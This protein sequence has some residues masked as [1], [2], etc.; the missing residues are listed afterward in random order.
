MLTLILR[1]ALTPMLIL[2]LMLLLTLILVLMLMSILNLI[3]ILLLRKGQSFFAHVV[4][5]LTWLLKLEMPL[6]AAFTMKSF[7][8]FSL[9]E[10]KR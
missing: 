7:L 5:H 9:G 4:R 6:G 8:F 10:K 3:F 1:L 2:I